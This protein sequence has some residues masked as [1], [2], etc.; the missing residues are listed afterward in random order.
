M[1][2]QSISLILVA[3]LEQFSSG[4]LA[5]LKRSGRFLDLSAVLKRGS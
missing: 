3:A 5:V 1:T 2:S 4:S